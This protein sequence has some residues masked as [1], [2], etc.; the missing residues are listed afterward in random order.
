[1]DV[2]KLL[3]RMSQNLSVQRAFGPAYEKDGT[4]VIPVALVAGGGGGGEGT[5]AA[6]P[7]DDEGVTDETASP[8]NGSGGGFGGVVMP[9]GVY[10]VKDDQ[11]RWVPS[12][13]V[14]LLALAALATLRV[15]VRA[16][17]HRR[18]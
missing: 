4:L 6:S 5:D 1:M 7:R 9:V 3:G 11:V 2:K 14:T 12:V 13:N 16:R 8:A 17:S 15:L 10:V 18:H